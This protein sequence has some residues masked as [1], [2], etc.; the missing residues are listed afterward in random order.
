MES[1]DVTLLSALS[2][3]ARMLAAELPTPLRRLRIG[4]ADLA[5]EIE[6][7]ESPAGDPVGRPPSTA[8]TT[9]Q[10]EPDGQVLVAAPLIGTF[11]E[12]PEPGAA[13]F[14]SVG[15]EV[16]KGQTIGIIEAM[17][18]MN[19]VAADSSG[20]VTAVL[21]GNGEAVEYGQP[22]IALSPTTV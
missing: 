22:L 19:P 6:W 21:V 3:H 12:A 5:V 10:T 9:T 7:Q 18:L 20:T 17:K 8:E 4:S 2:E 14:V 15:N 1:D 16:S 13:P 11:Y